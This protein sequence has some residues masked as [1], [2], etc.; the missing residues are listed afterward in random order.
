MKTEPL[1]EL[2]RVRPSDQIGPMSQKELFGEI[3]GMR[4][5]RPNAFENDLVFRF[6]ASAAWRS[7]RDAV[8]VRLGARSPKVLVLIFSRPLPASSGG[9]RRGD[10]STSTSTTHQHL[11]EGRAGPLTFSLRVEIVVI[12]STA[13]IR[14]RNAHLLLGIEGESRHVG[15]ASTR[16]LRL[17][18]NAFGLG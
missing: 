4:F 16:L 14:E 12:G 15:A 18:T 2:P 3:F 6:A 5:G 7:G 8:Y 13:T 1:P 10:A 9:M 17:H 11:L